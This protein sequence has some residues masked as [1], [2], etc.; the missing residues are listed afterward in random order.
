M[1]EAVTPF[2]ASATPTGL[3]SI[4]LEGRSTLLSIVVEPM[5]RFLAV[6]D[7]PVEILFGVLL[8]LVLFMTVANE[9]RQVAMAISDKKSEGWRNALLSYIGFL[10]IAV[11]MFATQY[12]T[13]LVETEWS[14]AGLGKTDTVVVGIFSVLMFIWFLVFVTSGARNSDNGG[15]GGESETTS[16]KKDS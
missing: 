6:F 8:L 7:Q 14:K 16:N 1:A 4:V 13:A 9:L 3:I 12:I 10:S 15:D 11:V 2:F 5:Q